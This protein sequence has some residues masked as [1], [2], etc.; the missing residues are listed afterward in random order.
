M[1]GFYCMWCEKC[2]RPRSDTEWSLKYH[3]EE[4]G[5]CPL[6]NRKFWL[7]HMVTQFLGIIFSFFLSLAC[8]GPN[9]DGSILKTY[10]ESDPIYHCHCDNPN[11]ISSYLDWGVPWLAF[12][13]FYPLTSTLLIEPEVSW[14]NI[15][16]ITIFLFP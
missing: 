1:T 11:I 13:C 5:C 14:E 15:N 4:Y 12:Y 9:H 7:C 3:A 10:P 2:K 6:R 16:Q 8:H